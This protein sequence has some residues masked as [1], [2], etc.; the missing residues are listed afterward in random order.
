MKKIF[1]LTLMLMMIAANCFAMIF[2]Q[3]QKI[4]SIGHYRDSYQGMPISGESYNSGKPYPDR[5]DEYNTAKTY[6]VGIARFGDG[7][8]ALYCSYNWKDRYLKFGGKDNYVISLGNELKYIYRIDSDEGLTLYVLL[9]GGCNIIGRQKNGQWF[10]YVDSDVLTD[11]YFNGKVAANR[12]TSE[13][14]VYKEDKVTVKGDTIIIPYLYRTDQHITTNGE[15]RFK[16]DDKAQ[17][18]GVEKITY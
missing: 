8:N 15:L 3:P 17:W 2:S 12:F 14:V 5:R 11:K 9:F 1:G 16:W 10:S 18:F 7:E 13:G 4:G 6:Y